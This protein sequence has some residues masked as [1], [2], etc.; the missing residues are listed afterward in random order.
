MKLSPS[1]LLLFG[2]ALSGSRRLE[3]AQFGC[4]LVIAQTLEVVGRL[5]SALMVTPALGLS[6]LFPAFKHPGP[7]SFSRAR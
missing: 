3:H 6:L 5:S 4:L 1:Y 2:V 7:K